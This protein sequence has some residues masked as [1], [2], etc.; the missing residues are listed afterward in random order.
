[1]RLLSTSSADLDLAAAA[2]VRG[3]LVAFPTETVYGLGA[4]ALNPAALAKVFAAK[5]RPVFDPLIVHI[6]SR[7]GLERAADL[8]ALPPKA[9]DRALALAAACWPGPLTL[10]LPKK[11]EVPDLATSG[12]ATVAVRW[13]AHPVALAL[14]ERSSGLVAAPSANPFGYLSPTRA[15]H[16]A[17]QLGERVDF[18]VDGGRCGLGV[19]STVLDLSSGVPTVLRP[20]GLAREAIEAVVGPVAV[21]DRTLAGGPAGTAGAPTA[22]G[23]LASHY[24]PRCPLRLYPRGGLAEAVAHPGEVL[25]FFSGAEREAYARERGAP[26]AC[27]TLTESGDTL[28]AAANLFDVL[29]EL[30]AAGVAG[31]HAERAPESGLGAAVN[32]RLYKARSAAR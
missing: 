11:P 18:I 25:L 31:I 26:P 29:H 5:R 28:E 9:A 4:D 22:P 17:A 30:D 23:Q 19:E 1:M 24:A 13:P 16:V 3:E 14:I 7:A 2:L 10:I 12:L 32:D 6:A 20:G 15:E 8:A 27:R 21:Y